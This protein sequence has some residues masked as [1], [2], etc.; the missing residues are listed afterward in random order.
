MELDIGQLEQAI[1]YRFK[2]FRLVQTALSHRSFV[3]ETK[4]DVGDN[5]RLE[6]LGDSVLGMIIAEELFRRHPNSD[7]G[8]LSGVQATLVCE[9]ALF[10]VAMKIKLGDFIQLGRGE[11]SSGGR[12][13]PSLLADAYEALLAAIYLDGGIESVREVIVGLHRELLERPRKEHSPEDNKSKLQRITQSNTAFRPSYEIVEERGP[14]HSRIFVAEVTIEGK[15]VGRGEG[16]TKKI[17]QQK[18]ALAALTVIDG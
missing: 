6:F 14:A 11:E 5:Q 12:Q 16:K 9:S 3:N 15:L 2:N 8:F 13:K 10:D 18:A 7:E 17:A 1:G 4:I